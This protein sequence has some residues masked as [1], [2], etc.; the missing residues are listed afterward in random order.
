M[1]QVALVL[2]DRVNVVITAT[3]HE[4]NGPAFEPRPGRNF[5]RPFR[6]ATRPTDASIKW[7]PGLFLRG[8][9]TGAFR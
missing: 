6:A 1:I 5:P 9:V 8:K 3:S 7:V 2:N 4:L